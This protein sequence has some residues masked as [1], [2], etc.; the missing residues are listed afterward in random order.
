MQVFKESHQA[1]QTP[2]MDSGSEEE[3]PQEP[4]VL[5]SEFHK[6]NE[7]P[8]ALGSQSRVG[9]LAVSKLGATLLG[10]GEGDDEDDDGKDLV[11]AVKKP[12][13][14]KREDR[15]GNPRSRKR[16]WDNPKPQH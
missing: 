7:T 15:G 14:K 16:N 4:Q 9:R 10:G 6:A 1:D 5:Y 2:Q 13:T 3:E 8:A 11:D 12:L